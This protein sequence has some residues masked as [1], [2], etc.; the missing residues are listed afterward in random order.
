MEVDILMIQ[1][2]ILEI[3]SKEA[4]GQYNRTKS[5]KNTIQ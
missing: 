3:L 4:P 5:E 2:Y 1:G